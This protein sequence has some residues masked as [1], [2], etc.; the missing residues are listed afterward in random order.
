[1]LTAVSAQPL[2]RFGGGEGQQR[3]LL[4]ANGLCTI[5]VEGT[6]LRRS[7]DVFLL[8]VRLLRSRDQGAYEVG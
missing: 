7:V 1:M 8:Q 4:T 3:W 2:E 5:A 6:D